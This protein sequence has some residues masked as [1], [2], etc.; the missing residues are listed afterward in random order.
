MHINLYATFRLH[1]G[2]KSFT[3]EL[4]DGSSV[5]QVISCIVQRYP[6]LGKDWLDETGELHAHVHIFVNGSDVANLSAGIDTP[7]INSDELD[8]FPPVAGGIHE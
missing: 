8:F 5:R 4:P 6:V 1:A 3:I 2:V 7:L